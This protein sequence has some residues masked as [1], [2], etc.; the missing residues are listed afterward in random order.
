M[1]ILTVI[2]VQILPYSFGAAMPSGTYPMPMKEAGRR[3]GG[4]SQ[5]YAV[6]DQALCIHG[7]SSIMVFCKQAC[8]RP[9]KQKHSIVV[10]WKGV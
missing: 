7:L 5:G 8:A 10:F 2:F 9:C 1:T 4:D 3:D 6:S